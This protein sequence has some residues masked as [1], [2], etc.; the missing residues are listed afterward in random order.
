MVAF[1]ENTEGFVI[2][3]FMKTLAFVE[4]VFSETIVDFTG[5][6]KSGS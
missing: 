6:T 3:V 4:A 5:W 1:L 2:F